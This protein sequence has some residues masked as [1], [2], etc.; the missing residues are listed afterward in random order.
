MSDPSLTSKG[1]ELTER[2]GK[3]IAKIL[4]TE[5]EGTVLRIAVS[6]GGCS[7]FQ[8][9]YNL[10]RETASEDDLVLERPGAL[11]LLD[12]M[13]VEFMNGAKI[14]YVDDLVGQAFKIDNPN[15][16]ASCGCGNSFNVA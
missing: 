16:V 6:G 2:A 10:V 12:S 13:S 8:Y 7:G 4:A 11:V 1:V 15:T 9:E 3:Q 5:P 14:D